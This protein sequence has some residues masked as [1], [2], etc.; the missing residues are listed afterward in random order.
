MKPPMPINATIIAIIYLRITFLLDSCWLIGA[1]R[2]QEKGEERPR[3]LSHVGDKLPDLSGFQEGL[4][5]ISFARDDLIRGERCP[6]L[7]HRGFSFFPSGAFRTQE[8]PRLDA[9]LPHSKLRSPYAF[10]ALDERSAS[11]PG[12]RLPSSHS[13]KAPPAVET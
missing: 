3:W 1:T 4:L 7:L 8:G 11:T 2:S 12:R 9:S 5:A 10:A 13:R 6:E